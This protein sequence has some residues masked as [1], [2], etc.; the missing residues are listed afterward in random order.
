MDGVG[1]VKYVS[2]KHCW[3]LPVRCYDLFHIVSVNISDVIGLVKENVEIKT[4]IKISRSFVSISFIC[5]LCLGIVN[6]INIK[7]TPIMHG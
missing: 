4:V 6:Y 5:F 7:Y 1:F 3:N 2:R